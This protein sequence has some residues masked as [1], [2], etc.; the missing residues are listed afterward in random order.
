MPKRS[1]M[2]GSFEKSFF[3]KK[4]SYFTSQNASIPT[5]PTPLKIAPQKIFPRIKTQ[6]CVKNAI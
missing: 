6:L 2:A 3:F 1:K 4:N 5:T